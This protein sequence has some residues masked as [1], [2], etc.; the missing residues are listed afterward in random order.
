MIYLP[1]FSECLK[2]IFAALVLLF[3]Y[4][5]RAEVSADPQDCYRNKNQELENKMILCCPVV[6]SRERLTVKNPEKCCG[7]ECQKG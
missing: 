2:I 6:T 1:F 4:F 5:A 7:F 3:R